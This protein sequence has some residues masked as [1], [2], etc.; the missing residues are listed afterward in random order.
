M[1]R[2]KYRKPEDVR[3]HIITIRT[4]KS[5]FE[6][7]NKFCRIRGRSKSQLLRAFIMKVIEG[8]S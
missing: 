1:A 4:T 6:K 3:D 8:Y 5:E 7:I 2:G